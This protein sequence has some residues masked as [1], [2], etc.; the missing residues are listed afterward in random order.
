MGDNGQGTVSTGAAGM[1]KNR[2]SFA[3]SKVHVA[4]MGPRV[5]PM[6]LAIWV[7][8]IMIVHFSKIHTLE[9]Q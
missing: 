8:Y 7:G 5:G 9:T 2:K 6:N 4:N 3:D 1:K